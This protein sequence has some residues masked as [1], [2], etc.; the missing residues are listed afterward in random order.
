[1]SER[2]DFLKSVLPRM[3]AADVALHNGDATARAAMWSARTL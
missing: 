3:E 1:M 2:D